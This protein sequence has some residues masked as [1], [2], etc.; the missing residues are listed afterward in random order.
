MNCSEYVSL[1]KMNAPDITFLLNKKNQ[2]GSFYIAWSEKGAGF[3][4][5]RRIHPPK[6]L[7]STPPPPSQPPGVWTAFQNSLLNDFEWSFSKFSGNQLNFR[8]ASFQPRSQAP[9]SAHFP[10]VSLSLSFC[11][12]LLPRL[13]GRLHCWL[14]AVCRILRFFDRFKRHS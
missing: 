1:R 14:A 9:I 10:L 4:E 7:W 5:P 2:F 13:P 3:G 12:A 6:I 11:A 8:Y